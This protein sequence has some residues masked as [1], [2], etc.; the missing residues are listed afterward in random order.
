MCIR[1]RPRS[2]RDGAWSDPPAHLLSSI[3]FG[4]AHIEKPKYLYGTEAIEHMALYTGMADRSQEGD[5]MVGRMAAYLGDELGLA[6]YDMWVLHD[7]MRLAGAAVDQGEMGDVCLMAL[8][9]LAGV[10]R[11][12]GY[13]SDE[14]DGQWQASGAIPGVNRFEVLD[15]EDLQ[16]QP[17]PPIWR[18]LSLIHISEPTRPY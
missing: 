16:G 13:D 8:M 6:A 5:L 18:Y 15:D 14:G 10:E 12:A 11:R 2:A 9:V 7:P 1:D 17:P 4:G 3:I